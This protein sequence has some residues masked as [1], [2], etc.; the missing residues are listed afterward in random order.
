MS[1]FRFFYAADIH[2]SEV[3]WRK[4]LNAGPFYRVDAV[5]LGGDIVGKA[6]V[7]IEVGAG[8]MGR[9]VLHGETY[10][11]ASELEFAAF[12][13]KVSDGGF[14]PYRAGPDEMQVLRTDDG[15]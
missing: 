9:A 7:P 10:E 14:Y 6:I 8:G 3:C 11:L 2:G 1:A 4:F 13:R 15:A 12:E 5:I